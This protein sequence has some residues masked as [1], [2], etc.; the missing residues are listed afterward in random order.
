MAKSV[1]EI[2]KEKYGDSDKDVILDGADFI[3]QKGYTLIPNYILYT[4]K[5]D[6]KAKLV[7]ATLLSYAWGEKDSAFPGQERLAQDTGLSERSVWQAL[8]DLEVAG[9]ITILRRGFN[10]TNK[11]ILHFRRK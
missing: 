6:S 2:L 9:F 11:Y 5:I 8:K 4:D 3:S 7:Y 10:L 1:K